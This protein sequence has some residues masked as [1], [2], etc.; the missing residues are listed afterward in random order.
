M[1]PGP[2]GE[3]RHRAGQEQ[4]RT[5]GGVG[6]VGAGHIEPAEQAGRQ[7]LPQI[8]LDQLHRRLAAAGVTGQVAQQVGVAVHDHQAGRPGRPPGLRG[9]GRD[10]Q[11]DQV[12]VAEQDYP[13]AG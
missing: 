6:R 2:R 1:P 12:I 9:E 5:G 10:G 11:A 4:L 7:R 3:R 13:L 8:V